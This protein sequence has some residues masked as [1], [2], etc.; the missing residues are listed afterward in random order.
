MLTD[1][2]FQFVKK[3]EL[4]EASDDDWQQARRPPRLYWRHPRDLSTETAPSPE[5]HFRLFKRNA[6]GKRTI[7]DFDL[8]TSELSPGTYQLRISQ[9][10]KNP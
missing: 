4:Y 5:G 7:M 1:N 6:E 3:L 9:V 2:D 10:E 8:D